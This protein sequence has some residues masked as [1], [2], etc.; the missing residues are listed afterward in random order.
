METVEPEDEGD[1][2]DPLDAETE[3]EFG[4]L[5]HGFGVST[6]HF[7]QDFDAGDCDFE[8]L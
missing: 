1:F 2:G 8:V 3:F 4:A 7:L 6:E 5:V